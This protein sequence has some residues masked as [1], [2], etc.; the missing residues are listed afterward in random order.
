MIFFSFHL[1]YMTQWFSQKISLDYLYLFS[2]QHAIDLQQWNKILCDQWYF[3]FIFGTNWK[4][5]YV[6]IGIDSVLAQLNWN[7]ESEMNLYLIT[8]IRYM[9]CVFEFRLFILLQYSL[10]ISYWKNTNTIIDY[11]HLNIVVTWVSLNLALL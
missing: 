4:I 6:V 7:K 5:N 9:L 8:M 2:A 11:L 3:K 1:G 10:T